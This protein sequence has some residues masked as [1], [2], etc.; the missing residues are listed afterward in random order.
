MSQ[1]TDSIEELVLQLEEIEQEMLLLRRKIEMAQQSGV[2]SNDES[3]KLCQLYNGQYNTTLNKIKYLIASQQKLILEES[4]GKICVFARGNI[5]ADHS[6]AIHEYRHYAAQ[7]GYERD[8]HV[9]FVRNTYSY[10]AGRTVEIGFV[11]ISKQLNDY[12]ERLDGDDT[13][14]INL[15]FG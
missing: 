10:S 13:E 7:A 4:E 14:F 2:D 15:L 3:T 9:S 12:V 1:S 5:D 6:D 8:Q 11:L